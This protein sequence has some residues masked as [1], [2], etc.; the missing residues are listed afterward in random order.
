MQ[1]CW[2]FW[3]LS[4]VA[5]LAQNAP[6]RYEDVKP[7]T[8][9]IKYKP[10]GNKSLAD[11]IFYRPSQTLS[12]ETQARWG[13]EKHTPT[14]DLSQPTIQQASQNPR[15]GENCRNWGY[16]Y[17][18]TLSPDRDIAQIINELR[19]MPEI[20]YAEPIYTN[21]ES[22]YVPNDPQANPSTN[23]AS[24]HLKTI[25]MYEAWD[26]QQGNSNILVGITDSDF[27]LALTDLVGQDFAPA[28]LNR[29]VVGNDNVLTNGLT[30]GTHVAN[31]VAGKANNGAGSAGICFNCKFFPVKVAT[32][33]TST[34][35]SITKGYEGTLL[36][37]VQPNCK[38]VNMSWGRRGLP[39]LFEL[40]FLQSIT[41][42]YDVVLVAAA[43]N[44]GNTTTPQNLFFPA[45][46]N[47]VVLSVAATNSADI[48]ADFSTFNTYVDLCA[49]GASIVTQSGTD[50]GTSFASPMVAGA[51]ALVRAQF[52]TLNE[53]QVRARIV[54]TTD[55]IYGLA[56]NANFAGKLGSGR[57]NV[58]RALSDPLTAVTLEN[59]N[60]VQGKRN[61]LF[62]GMISDL[63]LTMRNHLDATSNLQITLTTDSPHLTVLDGSATIASIGANASTT[64]AS[65]VFRLQVSNTVTANTPATLTLAYQVGAFSFTERINILLNPGLANNNN[66]NL[67]HDDKGFL[68]VSNQL[69]NSLNGLQWGNETFFTEAGLLLATSATK[70][71]NTVRSDPGL[72][73]SDFTAIGTNNENT[74]GNL[75]TTN[76][77]FEDLTNNADRI[78]VQ[79]EQRFYSW[80]EPNVQNAVV[81]EYKI[82]NI[83]GGTISDLYTGIF[84]NWD[85]GDGAKNFCNW[86]ENNVMGYA[87][88]AIV[89]PWYGG[90]TCLTERDVTNTSRKIHYYAFE[91]NPTT[92][93]INPNDGF[94]K[95]EKYNALSGGIARQTAGGGTGKDISNMLTVRIPE[96]KLGETK[97]VTFAYV[98]SDRLD[99]LKLRA[100]NIRARYRQAKTS[101]TPIVTNLST[102][103]NGSVIIKPTGGT[104]FNFY[105]EQPTSDNTPILHTGSALSVTNVTTNQKFWVACVDSVFASTAVAVDITVFT[106]KTTFTQPND[107]L[108][109]GGTQ[110]MT[111]T[112]T[113]TGATSWKW[114]IT[115]AGGTANGDVTFSGGT[116]AN[117]ATPI[118]KFSKNGNYTIKLT[119]QNTQGCKDSLT[120]TLFVYTDVTSALEEL[121]K[122]NTKVYP[123]PAQDVCNVAI[124]EVQDKITLTLFN[125][126]GKKIKHLT[127]QNLPEKPHTLFVKDLPAG[128]YIL[129]IRLR[130][131]TWR[132][133]IIVQ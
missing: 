16:I 5:V 106:H 86:D 42:D 121:L 91:N 89:N 37:A 67:S 83:A 22:L 108:N 103:A 19:Q 3:L 65:D 85:I 14:F 30:H 104:K 90:I 77:Q 128:T 26:I 88:E 54:S 56:G 133:K 71:S 53:K 98:V 130:Q 15:W 76:A 39:S 11:N 57:L 107:T 127:Y 124:A 59:Y 32:D 114:T 112:S 62:R 4:Q 58:L 61:S 120:T 122:K 8:I 70:V 36:A 99:S 43:G 51:V 123:N 64:N 111:F 68:G 126:A 28:N 94:T 75:L 95:T 92:G 131:G 23:P 34:T 27:N 55:N 81:I 52:P 102:C 116:N 82:R 80:N 21:Y 7:H 129:Q 46:Y 29:D 13:I 44:D 49:P 48:K 40:D 69:F 87:S 41:E 110:E 79:V 18:L 9:V 101:P 20:A 132:E 63:V 74:T 118:V 119:T 33:G 24:Y 25:K 109:L 113:A 17:T 97:V 10:Q 38:V 93:I 45:S 66:V 73:S 47:E 96:L 117:I 12:P 115:R 2:S 100:A 78:G 1:I 84:T 105:A 31:I 35:T 125:S 72:F 50:S 60:F 6:F